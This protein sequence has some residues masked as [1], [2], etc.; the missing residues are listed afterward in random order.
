MAIVLR[1]AGLED[2]PQWAAVSPYATILNC[3]LNNDGALQ[4][5]RFC[6]STTCQ[7]LAR[8]TAP[9]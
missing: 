9:C 3:G 7:Q 5:L 1:R 4:T 2:V 8:A 6:I